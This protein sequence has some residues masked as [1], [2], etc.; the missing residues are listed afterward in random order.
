M[1]FGGDGSGGGNIAPSLE[2]ATARVAVEVGDEDL[3]TEEDILAGGGAGG[4]Y[5][6]DDD[7]VVE[8]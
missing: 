2:P 4:G 5:W 7:A 3:V 8:G 6:E 1:A